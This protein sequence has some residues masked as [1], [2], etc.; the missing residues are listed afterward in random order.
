QDP[1]EVEPAM[2][3]GARATLAH[4]WMHRR[5]WMND[6][7]CVL[8]RQAESHLTFAEVQAWMSVV[9]LTGQMA[10]FSDDLARLEPDPPALIPL[11]LP[12]TT[13][14]VAPRGPVVGEMPATLLLAVERPWDAWQVVGLFNWRDDP[15][16]LVFDPAICGLGAKDAYHLFDLWSHE[17]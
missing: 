8:L 11:L 6:P 1:F 16:P 10:L 2:R 9:A 5:L 15:Q 14:R 17:H 12:P 13:E 7:D 4:I 3:N